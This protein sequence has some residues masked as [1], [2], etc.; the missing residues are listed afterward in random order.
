MRVRRIVALAASAALFVIILL[1]SVS[2]AELRRRAAFLRRSAGYELAGRRLEGSGAAFDREFFRFL[3][4]VRRSLPADARG[5]AI[6]APDPTTEALHLAS[7]HLAPVPV[8]LAPRRVPPRWIGAW[9]RLPV[10]EGSRLV[11]SLPN[12][13]LAFPP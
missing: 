1:L 2:P 12:G 11:R 3:E 4:N 7:Y 13:A 10:P 5:V 9:H 6:F 8:L